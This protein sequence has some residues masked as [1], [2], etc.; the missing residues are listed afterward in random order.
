M[1]S[2]LVSPFFTLP[3]GEY[4]VEFVHPEAPFAH[5]LDDG[6]AVV[7]ERIDRR[8]RRCARRR[9]DARAIAISSR[10]SSRGTLRLLMEALLRTV[11]ACAIRS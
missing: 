4:G 10:R 8:D 9:R 11:Q 5:P 6:T 2:S 7:V 3:L 1:R